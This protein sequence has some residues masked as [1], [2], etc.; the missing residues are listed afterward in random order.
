M[1]E[2][3]HRHCKVC[4]KVTAVGNETCSKACTAKRE[5]QLKTRQM[6]TYLIYAV[7]AILVVVLLVSYV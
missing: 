1:V 7:I 6:Y 2:N 5:Q 3:D 4:G